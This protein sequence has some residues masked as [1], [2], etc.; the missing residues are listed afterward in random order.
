MWDPPIMFVLA[1]DRWRLTKKVQKK[2]AGIQTELPGLQKCRSFTDTDFSSRQYRAAN[3]IKNR[4]VTN[5]QKPQQWGFCIYG[6][7]RRQPTI[8]STVA[9]SPPVLPGYL[10]L[11]LCFVLAEYQP[12]SCCPCIFPTISPATG[13]SIADN[14][15]SGPLPS[16]CIP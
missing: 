1:S 16:A 2:T 11:L 9:L 8:L 4:T 12:E 15:K 13:K 14:G 6:C 10:S 3:N 7:M 5:K